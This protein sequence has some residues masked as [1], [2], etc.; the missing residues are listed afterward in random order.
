M[1]TAPT[2]VQA[3]PTTAPGVAP[4][5]APTAYGLATPATYANH[6]APVDVASYIQQIGQAAAQ[7]A[8]ARQASMMAFDQHQ[9]AQEGPGQL[10]L[11]YTGADIA[12][13]GD[14]AYQDSGSNGTSLAA[15]LARSTIAGQQMENE[16]ALQHN[17]GQYQQQQN[18]IQQELVPEHAG[19]YL[20]MAHYYNAMSGV[21]NASVPLVQS[22]AATQK[23]AANLNAAKTLYQQHL[24]AMFP[25]LPSATGMPTAP[26]G[27]M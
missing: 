6:A 16:A 1:A 3:A 22:Q 10:A 7:A 25:T 4:K 9:T 5:F 15:S 14:S 21:K 27:G 11:G 2:T 24:S 20:G 23:T 12:H 17:Q 8:Q 13:A 18:A 26:T 19:E